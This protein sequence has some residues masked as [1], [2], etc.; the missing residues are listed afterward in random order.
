MVHLPLYN[1]NCTVGERSLGQCQQEIGIKILKYRPWISHWV[2]ALHSLVHGPALALVSRAGAGQ[3]P[4]PSLGPRPAGNPPQVPIR[5]RPSC[6]LLGPWLGPPGACAQ[7]SGEDRYF[8]TSNGLYNL[9]GLGPG[10]ILSSFKLVW[11]VAA[12][13]RTAQ[14]PPL[15]VGSSWL[16]ELPA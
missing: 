12:A 15:A 14:A 2:H 7:T 16:V 9:S 3:P 4:E 5:S 11:P 10:Y 8:H 6:S 13:A 1:L